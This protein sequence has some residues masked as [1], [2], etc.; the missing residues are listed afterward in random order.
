MRAISCRPASPQNSSRPGSE[1]QPPMLVRWLPGCRCA[2]PRMLVC[3]DVLSS[4]ESGQRCDS[5]G[6]AKRFPERAVSSSR[7]SYTQG[8]SCTWEYHEP[9]GASFFL[10]SGEG[11]QPAGGL[12]RE[13]VDQFGGIGLP[14]QCC[15]L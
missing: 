7:M 5:T 14:C 1:C 13:P 9:S 3:S 15:R 11:A 2:W 4:S 6:V 10:L 12:L 8:V